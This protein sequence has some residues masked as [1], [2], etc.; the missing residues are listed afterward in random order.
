[1]RCI[2]FCYLLSFFEE[3]RGF[4]AF[5]QVGTA[6]LLS[7]AAALFALKEAGADLRIIAPSCLHFIQENYSSGAFLAGNGDEIRDLEYTFYGLL[8]LGTLV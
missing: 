8:A 7:T 1:M 3:G 4:K 6:D 2:L 5:P